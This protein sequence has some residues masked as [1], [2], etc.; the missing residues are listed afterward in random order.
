MLNSVES[1]AV[2]KCTCGCTCNCVVIKSFA[3]G[4]KPGRNNFRNSQGY[5]SHIK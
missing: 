2:C 3:S 5:K 1:Y 4:M